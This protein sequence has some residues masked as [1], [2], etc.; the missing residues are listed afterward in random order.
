MKKKIYEY[1]NERTKKYA[2]R[3]RNRRIKKGKIENVEKKTRKKK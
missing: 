2:T 3:E 1:K